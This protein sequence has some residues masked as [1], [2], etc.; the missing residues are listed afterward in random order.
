MDQIK[1]RKIEDMFSIKGQEVMP[2][3]QVRDDIK[4]DLCL[5]EILLSNI[6]TIFTV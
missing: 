3:G 1:A 6:M 2:L 5:H 4:V